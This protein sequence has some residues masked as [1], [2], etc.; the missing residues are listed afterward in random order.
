MEDQDVEE[1]ININV[2]EQTKENY[3]RPYEYVEAH[4]NVLDEVPQ[5]YSHAKIPKLNQTRYIIKIKDHEFV[6]L[7][8]TR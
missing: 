7:E 2:I 8:V 5:S 6:D 3:L 1:N 4:V